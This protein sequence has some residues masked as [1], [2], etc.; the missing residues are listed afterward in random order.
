MAASRDQEPILANLLELYIHDFSEFIPVDVGPDGR[1][2]Y[3]NLPLYWTDPDRHPVLIRVDEQWAGFVLIVNAETDSGEQRLW[4]MAEFFVL[5][6]FRR[7]G[8]GQ[9]AAHEVWQRYPGRWQVRVMDAN[10]GARRFWERAIEQFAGQ[11]V[12]PALTESRGVPWHVFSFQT[13]PSGSS[14]A[15]R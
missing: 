13:G 15:A 5:R 8:I 1:F 14:S 12:G 6:G 10:A 11:P 4:D 3:P 2:G 9:I 7:R